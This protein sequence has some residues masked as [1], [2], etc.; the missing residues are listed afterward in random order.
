MKIFDN[1]HAQQ[2]LMLVLLHVIT[3]IRMGK[4]YKPE[5]ENNTA[6]IGV[7][8]A[9]SII[10][11]YHERFGSGEESE[12]SSMM[13]QTAVSPSVASIANA[14]H[15]ALTVDEANQALANRFIDSTKDFEP[16]SRA[17]QEAKSNPISPRKSNLGK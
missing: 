16:A 15:K 11:S 4:D 2:W 17:F 5:E 12:S 8:L 7:Y 9:D 6:A 3:C 14:V 1:A 10:G 13:G